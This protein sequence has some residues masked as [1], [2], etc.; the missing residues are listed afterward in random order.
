MQK[1]DCAFTAILLVNSAL[2]LHS[3][4]ICRMRD[5]VTGNEPGYWDILVNTMGMSLLLWN[6]QSRGGDRLVRQVWIRVFDIRLSCM[7]LK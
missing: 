4:S 6:L 1:N 7:C 2:V 3:T 5:Y